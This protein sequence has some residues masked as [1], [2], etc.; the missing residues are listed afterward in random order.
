MT[1]L[2]VHKW[3][4]AKKWQTFE[5]CGQIIEKKKKKK[6]GKKSTLKGNFTQS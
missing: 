2:F 3:P 5:K 1:P 4:T 6:P